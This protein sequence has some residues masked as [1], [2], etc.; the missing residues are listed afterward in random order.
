[1]SWAPWT[2]GDRLRAGRV[3]RSP[4]A[5]LRRAAAEAWTPTTPEIPAAAQKLESAQE[6]DVPPACRQ[7]SVRVAAEAG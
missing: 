7:T 1:M 6:T 3:S 2:P 4:A 5:E